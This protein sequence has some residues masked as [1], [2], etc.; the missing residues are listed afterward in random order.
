MRDG[1][2]GMT[3]CV[4]CYKCRVLKTRKEKTKKQR[5]FQCVSKYNVCIPSW[6][7]STHTHTVLQLKVGGF[8]ITKTH[9]E[10]EAA[11]VLN[12]SFSALLE[13]NQAH[14]Q[15]STEYQSS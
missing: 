11:K 3:F 10:N 14:R 4:A 6:M 13:E 5:L 2:R 9:D 1:V 7:N 15:H 12:I 8:E